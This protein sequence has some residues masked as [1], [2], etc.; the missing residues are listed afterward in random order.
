MTLEDIHA[1]PRKDNGRG[2]IAAIVV[3][4][5]QLCFMSGPLGGS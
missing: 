4:H 5:Q 3:N 2:E 1:K